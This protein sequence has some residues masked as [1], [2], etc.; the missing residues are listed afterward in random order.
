MKNG[1]LKDFLR[2]LL[3][4]GELDPVTVTMLQDA[5]IHAAQKLRL[6]L[7]DASDAYTILAAGHDL[8]KEVLGLDLSL[9]EVMDDTTTTTGFEDFLRSLRSTASSEP[10]RAMGLPDEHPQVSEEERQRLN[11]LLKDIKLD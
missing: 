2:R 1:E 3:D 10:K 11:A 4:E 6:S 8:F 7:R 9:L 5:S